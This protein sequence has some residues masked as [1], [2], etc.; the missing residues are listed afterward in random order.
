M[1]QCMQAVHYLKKLNW[2]SISKQFTT[3]VNPW[4]TVNLVVLVCPGGAATVA[5]GGMGAAT[6]AMGGVGAATVAA[7]P[8]P[9]ATTVAVG[10]GSDVTCKSLNY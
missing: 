9:A 2:Q 3:H 8:L 5:V 6:V 4:H 1:N 10:A 7:S